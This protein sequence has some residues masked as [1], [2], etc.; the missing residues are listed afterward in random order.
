MNCTRRMWLGAGLLMFAMVAP[1]AAQ[2]K[3]T[4][5]NYDFLLPNDTLKAPL[6][7]QVPIV[8]VSRG[9]NKA[10]W[11]KL[12]DFISMSTEEVVD[13]ASNKKFT[14][15]VAKIKLPLGLNVPPVVPAENPLTLARFELGKKLYYDP[16]LSSDGKVSCSSCHSPSKGFSDASK[17]STGIGQQRGGMN[18][19]TV[20]NSAFNRLQFWD[21]RAGSLEEQAQGPVQ[22]TVEM[23]DDKPNPWHAAVKRVRASKEYAGLFE[24]E[25]GHVATRDASAKA[26]ASYERLVLIGNA[27]QDRAEAAARARAIEEESTKFDPLPKDYEKVL[28]EAFAAKDTHALSALKL[29]IETDLAKVP[30]VAKS[31]SN[32]RVLFFNKARCNSCHV[33]ETYTDHTFHNLGVGA[34]DGKLPAD[35]VGRFGALSTGHKDPA[36][37]GAFKTPQL[38]GLL[39]SQPYMHDGSEKTLEEVVE[40]YDKGGNANEYLDTKMR[41]TDAE[42]AYM[43]A[44]AG[45]P[46]FKGTAPTVF[47]SGGWPII[48]KKLELTADEKKDLVLF[49]RALESDPVPALLLPTK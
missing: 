44:K 8:F 43:A 15:K 42:K 17:T 40:F 11:E 32:G 9:L 23:C 41:D 45:G 20:F 16:I 3:D 13:L 30:E 49:M 18:A 2:P 4:P 27:I 34:K 19:P 48:P 22:N 38:R 36:V 35:A 29:N 37:Y 28:K 33:G 26:I 31:I 12:T 1:V 14:R 39:A 21:G 24:K 25:F 10:E 6:T 7:E 47:T 5:P 46:A